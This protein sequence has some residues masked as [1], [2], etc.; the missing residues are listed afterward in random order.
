MVDMQR[1]FGVRSRRDTANSALEP[2]ALQHIA[3][4]SER[5]LL[6]SPDL[7]VGDWIFPKKKRALAPE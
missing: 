5:R 3:V 7:Q 1:N 6:Y 2:I 4:F